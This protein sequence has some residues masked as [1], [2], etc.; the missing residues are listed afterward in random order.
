MWR[1]FVHTDSPPSS[2]PLLAVSIVWKS[3]LVQT[4]ERL[5]IEALRS[6]V[7]TEWSVLLQHE[8]GKM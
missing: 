3:I 6:Y 7:I 8:I 5:D 1:L 4:L 2:V